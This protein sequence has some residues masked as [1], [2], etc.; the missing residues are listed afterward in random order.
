[1]RRYLLPLAV[2]L[3]I[4][5]LATSARAQFTGG[6]DDPFFLY[7]GYFLPQQAYFASIPRQEDVLRQMAV[8]RQFTAVTDRA[9]LFEPGSSLAGYDPFAA[10]GEQNGS[11]LPRVT[12]VGVVN[13]NI[14]GMGVGGYHNRVGSY[15]PA[16]RSGSSMAAHRAPASTLTPRFDSLGLSRT[17][18]RSFGGGMGGMGMGGMGMPGMGMG[19]LR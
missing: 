11:R 16:Y 1:M 2:V 19:G 10:F 3:G 7:Y 13:H 17:Q 14:S 9:G 4:S 15:F 6:F 5:S 18:R 12:A 8:Q